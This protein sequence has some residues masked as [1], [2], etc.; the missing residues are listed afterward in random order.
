MKKLRIANLRIVGL[1]LGTALFASGGALA[2]DIPI[3]VVGPMTG[4]YAT[5][6]QQLRNGAELAIAD[7]NA[8]GGVGG[9]KLKLEVGDDAC[10]PKQA[11]AVAESASRCRTLLFLVID[12]GLR[13]LQRRQRRPDHAG[14][15]QPYLHRT[16]DV[17][18]VPRLRPR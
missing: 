3:G 12:P 15:H 17:E 11:R 9:K 8:A 2:Q 6:G 7:I 10:D 16:Q 14:I 1:A 18:H 4:Q 5:F 13:S